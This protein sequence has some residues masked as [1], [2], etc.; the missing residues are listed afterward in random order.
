MLKM[1]VKSIDGTEYLFLEKGGFGY[2]VPKTYVP[3]FYVLK[4]VGK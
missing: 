3:P 4:R 1:V 2:R